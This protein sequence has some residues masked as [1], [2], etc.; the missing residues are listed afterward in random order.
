MNTW[1]LSLPLLLFFGGCATPRPDTA[2][3]KVVQALERYEVE[4]L[5]QD[6]YEEFPYGF[7]QGVILPSNAPPQQVVAE[8]IEQDGWTTNGITVVATRMVHIRAPRGLDRLLDPADLPALLDRRARTAFTA[9]LLKTP[10]GERVVI[11]E[12]SPPASGSSAP[13]NV[14][15]WFHKTYDPERVLNHP[16]AGNAR[17]VP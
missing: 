8:A 13:F 9:V 11:M 5:A 3:N 4:A 12:F 14:G 15:G 17:S 7:A 10:V 16:A 2:I 1:L 6:R